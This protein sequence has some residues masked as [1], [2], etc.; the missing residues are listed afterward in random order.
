MF[1]YSLCILFFGLSY[2]LL[3]ELIYLFKK[4]SKK[5]KTLTIMDI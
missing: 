3:Y 1:I 4:I 2:R 5:G